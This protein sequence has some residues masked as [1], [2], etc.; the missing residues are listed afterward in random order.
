MES[1]EYRPR[2]FLAMR[3]A[4]VGRLVPDRFN[5]QNK[6]SALRCPAARKGALIGTT[7]AGSPW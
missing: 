1:I 5:I 7:A 4:L 2:V 3:A 6:E